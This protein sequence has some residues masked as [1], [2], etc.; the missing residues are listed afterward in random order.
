MNGRL[1]GML[2]A[3]AATLL[4]LAACQPVMPRPEGTPQEATPQESA[5]A[6]EEITLYV[7]PELV[8]CVGVGPMKCMLV[9]ENPE[10]DY[11]YFY[12]QIEGF[13][14]E[15][16]Y[17]YELRVQVTPVENAP[18]DASSLK[19]TL[20]EV[21]SKEPV[22]GEAGD[23]AGLEGPMWLLV[24]VA[25]DSGAIVDV[26]AGVEATA[27]FADGSVSGSS[28]CNNYSASYT[29]D[30]DSLS[31]MPGPMT[32][33]AC[34]EPQMTV[35]MQLMAAYGATASYTIADGQL[36][37]LDAGGNPVATFVVQEPASLTGVTWVALF[38][39][40]GRGAA[41]SVL[42]DT[43]ITA[44]FGDDG[45]LSGSAGCNNYMGGYTTD[46]SSIVIEPPASTRK[47]CPDAIM[48]QEAEYLLA[49]PTAATFTIQGDKLEL[50]TADGA[51][52]A[53]YVAGGN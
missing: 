53:S 25:D 45:S 32:M 6:G 51:L 41:V 10:D 50:R 33:M 34:P 37:L 27:T 40:N 44:I 30:G 15:P 26:P 39:N 49:L 29:M 21:V 3:L 1:V 18:A 42:A 12:S 31:I 20:V 46:G 24:S 38:Y 5:S 11:T 35:E 36:S 14:F 2:V 17:E 43:E 28:G 16:G 19:Y 8:D 9:K 23:S 4:A 52:V 7:G 13:E 22:A 47:A 48:Q